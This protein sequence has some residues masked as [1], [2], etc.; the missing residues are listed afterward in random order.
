MKWIS[1][2]YISWLYT[3]IFHIVNQFVEDFRMIEDLPVLNVSF[4]NTLAFT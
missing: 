2:A 3:I 4:M 1:F